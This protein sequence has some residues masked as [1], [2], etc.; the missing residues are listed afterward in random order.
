MIVVVVVVVVVVVSIGV[1]LKCVCMC[2]WL[3]P[4]LCLDLPSLYVRLVEWE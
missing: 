1:T 4:I 3:P 2:G